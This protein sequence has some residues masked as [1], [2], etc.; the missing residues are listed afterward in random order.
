[1]VEIRLTEGKRVDCRPSMKNK[2][3]SDTPVARWDQ[4]G[5]TLRSTRSFAGR[6]S[7]T[8][9]F[10]A[11]R[12]TRAC[13]RCRQCMEVLRTGAPESAFSRL[14]GTACTSTALARNARTG[15]HR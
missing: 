9:G 7:L 11:A 12:L 8:Q 14:S 5:F 1:M 6:E 3:N 2:T 13:A 4:G 15:R 10:A